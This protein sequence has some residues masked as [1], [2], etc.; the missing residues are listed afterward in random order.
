MWNLSLPWWE[1][2]LRGLIVYVFLILILRIT[3][4]ARPASSRPSISC[5]CWS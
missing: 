2:V 4:N 5:C 3:G 1:F